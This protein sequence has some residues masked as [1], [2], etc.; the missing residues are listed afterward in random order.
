MSGTLIWSVKN[1]P[2]NI[3]KSVKTADITADPATKFLIVDA[4]SEYENLA[5]LKYTVSKL[6]RE[7]KL[8]ESYKCMTLP[9]AWNLGMM[10]CNTDNVFFASS[11]VV[12]TKQGWDKALDQFLNQVPYILI[13]N[14]S[15][16]GLNLKVMIPSVGWFDENFKSGPHFDPDY[17]IRTY[18]AGL[19]IGSIPNTY[20]IHEDDIETK[21]K[22]LTSDVK[23]RLPMNDFFNENYFK[24]KWNTSWPGWKDAIERK[25]LDMPHPP[26]HISQVSRN[27]PEINFH[28][29]YK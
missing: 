13:D 24:Q 3:I 26:T 14:H 6:E 27:I 2:D 28:P 1:R 17:M 4:A 18:E 10:L 16:F 7:V 25:E 29:G 19:Q 8:I 5:K 15:V 11:D 12:F 23:D 22:R 21:E 9:Q 20:Y